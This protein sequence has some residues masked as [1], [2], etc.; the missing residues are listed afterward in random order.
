MSFITQLMFASFAILFVLWLSYWLRGSDSP[1][2]PLIFW[3]FAQ[4]NCLLVVLGIGLLQAHLDCL[5]L[6]GDC[7]AREYPAWLANYKPLLLHSITLWCLLALSATAVNFIHV[8]RR[9]Q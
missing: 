7:Y 3:W 2:I 5:S 4:I 1:K 8:L 9:K 6:W